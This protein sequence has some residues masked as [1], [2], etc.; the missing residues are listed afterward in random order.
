MNPARVV[1][2][3]IGG[4]GAFNLYKL[5]EKIELY[6]LSCGKN[7]KGPCKM[8]TL[9]NTNPLK[10]SCSISCQA[11]AEFNPWMLWITRTWSWLYIG[12]QNIWF[13]FI[14]ILYFSKYGNMKLGKPND[15]PD[16][17]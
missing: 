2:T 17:R 7:A 4:E 14:V 3:I 1:W 12:T 5:A 6:A 13:I 16:F 8:H 10:E 9:V 15:K 11:S